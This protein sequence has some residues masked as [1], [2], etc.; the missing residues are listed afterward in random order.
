MLAGEQLMS[1]RVVGLEFAYH[2][3]FDWIGSWDSELDG[4]LPIAV[5]VTVTIADP[6]DD[7]SVITMD[8]V[9][10]IKVALPTAVLPDDTSAG[11]F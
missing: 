11:G 7:E 8:N 5:Q 6:S 3:G 4:G 1:D 10:Q 2:D 9:F